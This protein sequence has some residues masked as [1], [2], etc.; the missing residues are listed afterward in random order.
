MADWVYRLD[1]K[2]LWRREEEG[3]LTI[4]EL[5]KLVAERIRQLPCYEKYIDD[6]E[7]IVNEFEYC[8]G[9]VEEFDSILE[10]LYDWADTPLHT[11][12]GQMQRRICWVKTF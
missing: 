9:D 12:K 5:A 2:D 10:R 1:L 11:R 7:E 4:K 3:E 8:C 6:L